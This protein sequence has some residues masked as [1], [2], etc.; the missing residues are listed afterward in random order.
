MCAFIFSSHKT[1]FDVFF[2]KQ[3]IAGCNPRY[4]EGRDQED[5]GLKPAQAK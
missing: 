2:K 4:S 5:H 1:S 3:F